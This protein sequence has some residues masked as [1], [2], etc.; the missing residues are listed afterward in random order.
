MG[1]P[2]HSQK[3]LTKELLMRFVNKVP[4]QHYYF[5]STL[6]LFILEI[7][8]FYHVF[9]IIFHNKFMAFFYSTLNIF[10]IHFIKVIFIRK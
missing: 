6:T 7:I 1:Y 9:I 10:N 4:I 5:T 8:I 2:I 3:L